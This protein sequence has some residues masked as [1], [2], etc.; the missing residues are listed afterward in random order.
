MLF[1]TLKGGVLMGD[2]KG[3]EWKNIRSNQ[4]ENYHR[5]KKIKFHVKFERVGNK[6]F[7]FSERH[8]YSMQYICGVFLEPNYR[9]FFLNDE[10]KN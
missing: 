10:K 5:R 6:T 8:T 2:K 1:K 7:F 4:D 9:V 3:N